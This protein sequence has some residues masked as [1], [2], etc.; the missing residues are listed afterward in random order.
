MSLGSVMSSNIRS[1]QESDQV[2][3][4]DMIATAKKQRV[5]D[6]FFHRVT[7][8]FSLL[9]LVALLGIIVSLFVNAWPTFQK[10]GLHFLTHIE[11]DIVNED[12]GAAIAIV[13]TV[14]SATIALLIAV[15]LAFG[16]AVF[17]TETC[18]GGSTL[19]VQT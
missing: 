1:F 3:S 19:N 7:Q 12:F 15:P 11:W 18:L 9:V 4:K 13:G 5:Q 2:V 14:A 16:V 8:A 10:F 6:F 17:L